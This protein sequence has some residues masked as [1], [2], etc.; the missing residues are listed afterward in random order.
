MSTRGRGPEKVKHV[1]VTL[2]DIN[3]FHSGKSKKD[4]FSVGFKFNYILSYY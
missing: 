3:T 1:N 2:Y 4:I